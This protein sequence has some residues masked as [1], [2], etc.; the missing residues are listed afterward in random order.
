MRPE[1]RP[2]K[3]TRRSASPRGKVFR[4]MASVSR[5]GMRYVGTP[6]ASRGG[7]ETDAPRKTSARAELNYL[8]YAMSVRNDGVA[9]SVEKSCA[10]SRMSARRHVQNDESTLAEF[11]PKQSCRARRLLNQSLRRAVPVSRRRSPCAMN[12]TRIY[13]PTKRQQGLAS[14]SFKPCVIRTLQGTPDSV[15]YGSSD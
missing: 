8:P 14:H 12:L 15:N 13:A 5:A 6:T 9:E 10:A 3:L 4:M 11:D 2:R 7:N 1:L